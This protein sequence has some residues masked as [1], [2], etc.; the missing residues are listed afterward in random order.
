MDVINN[1][2][3]THGFSPNELTSYLAKAKGLHVL[4][5]DKGGDVLPMVIQGKLRECKNPVK[6][7]E[8]VDKLLEIILS[9]RNKLE[10]VIKESRDIS[11]RYTNKKFR[12]SKV[13]FAPGDF[14]LVS[15]IGTPWLC[16]RISHRWIGP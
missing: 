7:K 14:I 9:R 6:F 16:D 5:S 10:P 1:S 12:S 2:K 13:N 11:R 8:A 4:S 3:S 15:R